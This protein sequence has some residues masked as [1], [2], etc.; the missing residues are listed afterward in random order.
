MLPYDT[1]EP[2]LMKICGGDTELLQME[3]AAAPSVRR[4][5]SLLRGKAIGRC[6]TEV[7][8]AFIKNHKKLLAGE[9]SGDMLG[10]CPAAC[11]MALPKPSNWRAIRFLMRGAKWK[12]KSARLLVWISCWMHFAMQPGNYAYRRNCRSA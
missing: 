11:A 6:V 9:F 1:V 12:L 10:D 8:K 7:A 2:L 3:V 5:I 4:K